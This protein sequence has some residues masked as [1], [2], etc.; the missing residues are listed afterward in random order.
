[1]TITG[2]YFLTLAKSESFEI[3]IETAVKGISSLKA[4]RARGSSRMFKL[5]ASWTY[6][7]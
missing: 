2:Y 5:R 3:P 7:R 4:Y 6:I 1:L